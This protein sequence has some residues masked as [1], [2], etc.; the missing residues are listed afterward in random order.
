MRPALAVHR[1]NL[2]IKMHPKKIINT[3]FEVALP[4]VYSMFL[5]LFTFVLKPQD[6]AAEHFFNTTSLSPLSC[7]NGSSVLFAPNGPAETAVMD[8]LMSSRAIYQPQGSGCI[9][10]GFRSYSEMRVALL[11]NGSALRS[12]TPAAVVFDLAANASLSYTL[13]LAQLDNTYPPFDASETSLRSYQM[14]TSASQHSG[15]NWWQYTGG[16]ALEVALDRILANGHTAG[17][18]A[19]MDQIGGTPRDLT[20]ARLPLPGFHSNYAPNSDYVLYI[21]PFYIVYGVMSI[22]FQTLKPMVV[23]REKR[24]VEGMSMMG[25]TTFHNSAGWYL[26]Y[27]MIHCLAPLAATIITSVAGFINDSSLVLFF[28]TMLWHTMGTVVMIFFVLPL[29]PSC[30]CCRSSCIP[31][32]APSLRGLNR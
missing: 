29:C 9:L 13:M 14:D 26:S 10:R 25:L 31:S 24:L 32:V 21:L 3:V 17:A 4:L 6:S 11:A 19:V 20:M 18:S 1:K 5:F 15:D 30:E 27:A 2:I 28:F 22:G 12:S 16:F 8:A 23:E 7:R